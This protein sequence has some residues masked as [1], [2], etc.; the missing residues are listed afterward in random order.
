MTTSGGGLF[1][2][3]A[4]IIFPG[5]PK[6]GEYDLWVEDATWSAPGGYVI[7]VNRTEAAGYANT[8]G[9]VRFTRTTG[10]RGVDP[11]PARD[12]DWRHTGGL[13]RRPL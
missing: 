4:R 3:D 8:P 10:S 6:Q 9:F 11:Q 12:P 2:L 13:S 7:S 1:G 5:R